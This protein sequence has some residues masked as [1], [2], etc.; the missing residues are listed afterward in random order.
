MRINA[1]IAQA[2]GVSRR[3]ADRLIAQGRVS[4]NDHLADIGMQ[5]D[6]STKVVLDGKE[7]KALLQLTTI[8]FNKPVGYVVS[9]EGQGSKTVYDLLPKQFQELKPVGRLDKDSSGLI[10]FTNDGQLANN[11]THPSFAKLK[12]Y[13]ITINKPL[14][15]KDQN[16]IKRGVRLNDGISRLNLSDLS[17]DL[18]SLSITMSEGRNRQI[19]RTFESLGY[20]VVKLHRTH[21]GQFELADLGRGEWRKVQS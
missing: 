5:I 8:M 19:R 11:L 3:Q 18:K 7:I 1:F 17:S 12:H 21:F 9:R 2:T 4:I 16:A 13:Q 20:K 10:L 6:P 15:S 14:D